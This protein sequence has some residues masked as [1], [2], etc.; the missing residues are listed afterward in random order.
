MK[1]SIATK[2]ATV[3]VI[4]VVLLA[5]LL[6]FFSLTTL[7]NKIQEEITSKM[8]A[9]ASHRMNKVDR[10]FFE[11]LSDIRLLTADRYGIL[12]NDIYTTDEKIKYLQTIQK[13]KKVYESIS[14]YSVEGIKIG[15]SKE[16]GVGNNIS[17]QIYYKYA[18][19]GFI[20]VDEKP[21]HS[22]ELQANVIHFSGPVY[23][24]NGTIKNILVFRFLIDTINRIV[25]DDANPD[26]DTTMDLV[27]QE[28]SIIYSNHRLS[29]DSVANLEIFRKV[30]GSY[31]GSA[32]SIEQLGEE[33]TLIVAVQQT[34]YEEYI[35]EK[36]VL[37]MGVP[38]RIAFASVSEL[39]K[40][41]IVLTGLFLGV[42]LSLSLLLSHFI[43]KPITEL[44]ESAK[45]LAHGK[46]TTKVNIN[47]GDE[48]Q[49]LGEVFNQAT[50]SLAESEKKREEL[51]KIK[52]RFM[53]M[54]T[55]ELKNPV[56]AMLMTLRM[57]VENQ[58]GKFTKK[59]DKWIK[60]LFSST[61]QLSNILEDFMVF[62]KLGQAR[63]QF[64][65]QKTDLTPNIRNL[66]MEMRGVDPEK[67]LDMQL[68]MGKL[69]VFEVDPSRVMQVLRNIINNAIKFSN[70]NG[71]IIVRVE[72]KEKHL[73]FSVQDFGRGIA[74]EH[75][76]TL[77]EPF[78]QGA[79]STFKDYGGSG[80]GTTI[81]K[82]IIECQKGKIWFDSELGKGTTFFF[83]V[84][85][86]PVKKI[87]P[88]KSMLVG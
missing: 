77:F 12:S 58:F 64:A 34:G 10:F 5:A 29:G 55:H 62:S 2:N 9:D 38:K 8:I 41:T 63:L 40:R 30:K 43:T 51:E 88:I 60:M 82:G 36:W 23:S 73:L 16:I 24:P 80:L 68:K 61:T 17:D 76:K 15:D 48:L 1:A 28:G 66:V 87:K 78:N 44:S 67:N 13:K 83:T 59:Q 54:V 75:Q 79:D 39:K 35:G 37:L 6:S 20:Y 50:D 47:S 52:A 25:T 45:K 7:T 31:T 27:D 57:M 71:K 86:K 46:F 69:P 49:Q 33:E 22:D 85:Y 72:R 21:I 74:K 81:C 84:P 4:S 14:L 11:R 18:I 26:F 32:T 70:K 56:A 53:S 65:F 19:T 42:V 3:L